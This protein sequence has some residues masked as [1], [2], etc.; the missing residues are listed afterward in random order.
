MPIVP[1]IQERL[2]TAFPRSSNVSLFRAVQEG[3][4]LA[5]HLIEGESFLNNSLGR[6][7]HG[8]IR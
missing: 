3:C 2:L 5:S 4:F 7:L 8:H 1:E 6:D